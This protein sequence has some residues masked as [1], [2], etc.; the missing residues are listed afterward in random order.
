MM[1]AL[2]YKQ[3]I[4]HFVYPAA[5]DNLLWYM[6][7]GVKH[8]CLEAHQLPISGVLRPLILIWICYSNLHQTRKKQCSD[9]YLP[10]DSQGHKLFTN[11]IILLLWRPKT[12]WAKCTCLVCLWMSKLNMYFSSTN[13]KHKSQWFSRTNTCTCNM[14]KIWKASFTK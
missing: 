4:P 8:C 10:V 14:S 11:L 7:C 2:E 12:K 6:L 13:E 3:A 5:V 9:L 1:Q